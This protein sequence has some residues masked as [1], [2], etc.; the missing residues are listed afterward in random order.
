M[1][2]QRQ[3]QEARR[4]L[5]VSR[6]LWAFQVLLLILIFF[7]WLVWDRLFPIF[8]L[9]T[10]HC[11]EQ[12]VSFGGRGGLPHIYTLLA[13]VTGLIA[14]FW[15]VIAF[16]FRRAFRH[17]MTYALH[18]ALLISLFFLFFDFRA[19]RVDNILPPDGTLAVQPMIMDNSASPPQFFPAEYRG[20]D[21]GHWKFIESR[22][23][24]WWRGGYRS[25]ECVWLDRNL[26]SQD[27]LHVVPGYAALSKYAK[28]KLGRTVHNYESDWHDIPF[29]ESVLMSIGSTFGDTSMMERLQSAQTY[30]PLLAEER[31]RFLNKQDCLKKQIYATGHNQ[32]CQYIWIPEWEE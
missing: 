11:V 23:K 5:E 10:S 25:P 20:S 14:L 17:W 7:T 27:P 32:K 31:A 26:I 12:A 29:M 13:Y 2:R 4:F 3:R 30:R 24:V 22:N 16:T 15:A 21:G 18:L 19:M 28:E 9:T 6:S 1:K 8:T